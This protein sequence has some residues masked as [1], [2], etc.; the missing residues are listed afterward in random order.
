MKSVKTIANVDIPTSY[1][2]AI[3]SE[4]SE[5]WLLAM[6]EEI[7]SLKKNGTWIL[8]E[9]PENFNIIDCKLVFQVKK[10]SEGNERCK[11]R[12]VAR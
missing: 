1:E 2:Q 7:N 3:N 11:A 4:E 5:R 12:L 10:S 6:Q 9:K 8:E